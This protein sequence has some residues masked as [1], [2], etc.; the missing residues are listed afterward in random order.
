MKIGDFELQVKTDASAL[1]L[2]YT[3]KCINMPQYGVGLRFGLENEKIVPCILPILCI[4]GRESVF[5]ATD[6]EVLV[7]FFDVPLELR[8]LSCLV[9]RKVLA[10]MEG[11]TEIATL[12]IKQSNCETKIWRINA[13]K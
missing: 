9:E 13:D 11:Q 3:Y 1:D 6:I 4:D 12:D 7:N 10:F 8:E 5:D 2:R